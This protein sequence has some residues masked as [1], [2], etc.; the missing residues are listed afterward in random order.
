MLKLNV[1]VSNKDQR[2]DYEIMKCEIARKYNVD[3]V[4]VI[5]VYK[6]HIKPLWNSIKHWHENNI[7]DA[8]T[9]CSVPLYESCIFD[10]P[11]MDTFKRHYEY[12]VRAFT[13]HVTSRELFERALNAGFIINSRGGQFL[14]D[15][16]TQG[17]E[18][19]ILE[20]L[21]EIIDFCR[22]HNCEL[23]LGTSLRPGTV[24]K[25][26][27][28]FKAA[29]IQ[30]LYDAKK[31]WEYIVKKGVICQVECLGHV[32]YNELETYKSIFG[33][34]PL[35]V[36]GPLLTDSVNGFDDINAII[37]YAYASQKLNIATI[38]MLS[39]KE[40]ISLP[41]IEDVE[42]ECQKWRVAQHVVGLTQHDPLSIYEESKVL[43]VKANQRTQCSA[44][45][46]IFGKINMPEKCNV[47]GSMC[48]LIRMQEV[49]SAK[50]NRSK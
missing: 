25:N 39:R 49:N 50:D 7:S 3:Y 15:I 42:D 40:H 19:P 38:C 41:D 8:P 45:V 12:G 21:D 14:W 6:D 33:E 35:C 30:E 13:I 34:T 23:M 11:L 5:S 46:N 37:G 4:S 1:G 47:C 31:I 2:L 26:M 24:E 32:H 16:F 48:P 29:T 10:E 9:L 36:M 22:E 28:L 43:K 20:H 44:H 17:K 18:N 27:T